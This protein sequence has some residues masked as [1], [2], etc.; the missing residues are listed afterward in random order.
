MLELKISQKIFLQTEE[1]KVD[2]I[3]QHIERGRQLIIEDSNLGMKFMNMGV[4]DCHT[5]DHRAL[6]QMV[7][8]TVPITSNSI[9]PHLWIYRPL[10]TIDHVSLS[11]E[12]DTE[13]AD[14]SVLREFLR[15]VYI[16]ALCY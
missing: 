14:L 16:I 3:E 5:V 15:Q 10:I 6:L 9:M 13:S 1:G 12:K 2:V 8:E 4:I 7:Y 11:L